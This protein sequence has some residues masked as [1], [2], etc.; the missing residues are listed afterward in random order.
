MILS[1]IDI[2]C[3]NYKIGTHPTPV[4]LFQNSM[5]GGAW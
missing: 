1:E 3:E 2:I 4:F 5:D